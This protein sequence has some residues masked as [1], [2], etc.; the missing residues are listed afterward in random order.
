MAE[1]L[2]YM[3]ALGKKMGVAPPAL[4]FITPPPPPFRH[5]TPVSMN[6]IV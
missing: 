5:A 1:V 4:L 3:Q 6:M 2:Q